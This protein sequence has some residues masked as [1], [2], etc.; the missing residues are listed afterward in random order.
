MLGLTMSKFRSLAALLMTFAMAGASRAEAPSTID[1][2]TLAAALDAATNGNPPANVTFT[3]SQGANGTTIAEISPSGKITIYVP[4][5]DSTFLLSARF[6]GLNTPYARGILC[7]TVLHELAHLCDG[8]TGPEDTY[9]C[10]HVAIRYGVA[11]AECAMVTDIM[12]YKHSPDDE[13]FACGLCADYREQQ[14][15]FN[16]E[17]HGQD[18]VKACLCKNPPYQPPANCP[19]MTMPPPPPGGCPDGTYPQCTV[20]PDCEICDTLHCP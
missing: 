9:S 4:T 16:Q 14:R 6:G 3:Q 8:Q 15:Y 20:L 2:A 1:P 13:A 7:G 12:S 5:L 17:C 10:E 19:N 11:M 18:A